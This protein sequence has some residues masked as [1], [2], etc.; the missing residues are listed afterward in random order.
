MQKGIIIFYLI[1]I[2]VDGMPRLL[3]ILPLR[4]HHKALLLFCTL[5]F[6][7]NCAVQISP[8]AKI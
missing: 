3:F 8:S 7:T 1:I 4:A 6:V 5:L 2:T